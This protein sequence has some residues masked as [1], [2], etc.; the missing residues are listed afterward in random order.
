MFF[1]WRNFFRKR[2]IFSTGMRNIRSSSGTDLSSAPPTAR[3]NPAIARLSGITLAQKVE[4]PVWGAA[5]I[6]A[7]PGKIG[8]DGSPTRVVK[9]V[10]PEG[11]GRE[12]LT[13][14]GTPAQNAQTVRC[15]LAGLGIQTGGQTA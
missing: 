3:N 2:T 4:I 5:D 9:A 1:R 12:T 10:P 13:L 7:E 8:L 14:T 6:G 11:R 15:L